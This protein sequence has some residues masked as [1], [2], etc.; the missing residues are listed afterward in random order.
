MVVITCCVSK[1]LDIFYHQLFRCCVVCTEWYSINTHKYSVHIQVYSCTMCTPWWCT[2]VLC[3]PLWWCTPV[4]CVPPLVVYSCTMCTPWWCTP[5]LCV[6]LVVYSCTLCTPWWY[7]PALLVVPGD[8]FALHGTGLLCREDHEMLDR[9]DN[10][11]L[12]IKKE[13]QDPFRYIYIY[14]IH[15]YINIWVCYR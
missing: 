2:P 3:Y 12:T 6:A 10:N 9:E 15:T 1:S 4:V 13:F 11:N 7:T 5:V 8:E 14:N